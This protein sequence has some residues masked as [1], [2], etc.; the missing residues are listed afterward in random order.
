MDVDTIKPGADFATVI[1]RA[2]A[3]YRILIALIGPT[4]LAGTG[5]WRRRRLDDPGDLV[6]M[7]IGAALA[8]GIPVIRCSS[9]AL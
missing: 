8:R 9:M 3:A 7:E 1:A 6:A 5:R 4:W 2:L